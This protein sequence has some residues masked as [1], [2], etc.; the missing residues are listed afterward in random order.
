MSL[1][2]LNRMKKSFFGVEV[3]HSV[4][5]TLE[6]GEVHALIGE[7]GA[8]KS[9][10]MKLLMG[11]YRPDGGEIVLDGTPVKIGSPAEALRHGIAKVHQELSPILD[12]SVADNLFLGRESKRFGLVRE[13]DQLRRA[14]ELFEKLGLTLDPRRLMRELSVAETQMVE[15]AKAVSY[16]SR[17]LILDE[18]TSAITHV[19]V[20]KL[21]SMIRLLKSRGVGIIYISHKLE[22]LYEISDRITVLRDGSHVLTDDTKSLPK[23]KLINA[24]VGREL[25]ELY[26]RTKNEVGTPLLEVRELTRAGEFRNVSFTLR[27][28]EIVGLAGLMGSGRTEICMALF[29]AA[30]P[31]AGE[32]LLD[33]RPVRL[34]RPAD[35]ISKGIALISEDRKREGLN[36]QGSVADNIL[37]VVQRRYA[38]AGFLDGRRSRGA[39]Q[40]MVEEFRI[41]VHE[42]GQSVS[43]L[44]GGNQQKV[45]VAK[46]KLTQPDILI[47]DEPTRGVDVGAK[48]EI[49]RIINGFAQ[50]GKAVLMVSSE[51]PEIIGMCDRVL[52]L[53]AGRLTGEL[54]GERITQ[55]EIMKLASGL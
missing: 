32:I 16:D 25:T 47:F 42:V 31:D 48:A 34:R 19:E 41:K 15:I 51:M 53:H 23:P 3:L 37:G 43:N 21:F 4:D 39:V 55:Q 2:T 10:L 35:A 38:R 46:W 49:Y 45:V 44:S 26:P 30:R 22:E 24:M 20:E 33:G 12:M 5:F 6:A 36:L 8:G 28:G 11:E 14:R 52:V 13:G 29:G 40:Q 7:N 18:P 17:V 50:Q 54:T 1:L 9:T 27:R